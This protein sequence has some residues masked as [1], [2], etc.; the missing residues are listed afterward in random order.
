MPR[1]RFQ[2]RQGTAAEWTEQNPV[3]L[4]GEPGH[5][6]DTNLWKIGDGTSDWVSLGYVGGGGGEGGGLTVE[7]VQDIVGAMIVQ[8]TNV[9]TSYNDTDGTVTVSSTASGGLTTEQ[10]Q[11]IVGAMLVEGS[12]VTTTYDDV[13]GTVT[14][15]STG[16]GGGDPLPVSFET[17]AAYEGLNL[18]FGAG[19]LPAAS[20]MPN[21][22]YF[23]LPS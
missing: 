22:V 2:F 21:T 8:G 18:Y 9:T 17:D 14:I 15:S 10:V 1:L 7:Q 3:L 12:N 16:G 4:R 13:A 23:V 20:T 19:P 11:D 5:E 6:E